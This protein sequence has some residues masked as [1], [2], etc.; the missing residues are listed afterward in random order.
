M[1]LIF[2]FHIGET[3]YAEC[4]KRLSLPYKLDGYI[5]ELTIPEN[6]KL[7]RLKDVVNKIITV[8]RIVQV[9]IM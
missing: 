4:F 1:P 5:L 9:K 2:S 8:V 7:R 3:S 6:I